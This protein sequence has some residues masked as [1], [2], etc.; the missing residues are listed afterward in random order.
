MQQLQVDKDVFAWLVDFGLV[1]PKGGG[2]GAKVAASGPQVL[3]VRLVAGLLSGELMVE[4]LNSIF[5]KHH[6]KVELLAHVGDRLKTWQQVCRGLRKL[7]C[8]LDD[9]S[10]QALAGGDIDLVVELLSEVMQVYKHWAAMEARKRRKQQQLQNQRRTGGSKGAGYANGYGGHP[11]VVASSGAPSP[12][13]KSAHADDTAARGGGASS[14]TSPARAAPRSD[15]APEEAL[16]VAASS[17]PVTAEQQQQHQQQQLQDSTPREPHADER[18]LA[19]ASP[20]PGP[21]HQPGDDALA[22]DEMARVLDRGPGLPAVHSLE[23]CSL[24]EWATALSSLTPGRSLDGATSAPELLAAAMMQDLK[25]KPEQARSLLLEDARR[26][27]RAFLDSHERNCGHL[28]RWLETLSIYSRPMAEL[29][30]LQPRFVVPVLGAVGH[31]LRAASPAVAE[32]A[33]KVLAGIC[34]GLSSHRLGRSYVVAWVDESPLLTDLVALLVK[35]PKASVT[36]AAFVA[37]YGG[38]SPKAF[39]TLFSQQLKQA[40][41]GEQEYLGTV[42]LLLKAFLEHP[43]DIPEAAEACARQGVVSHFLHRCVQRLGDDWNTPGTQQAA[44][45]MA[46]ELWLCVAARGGRAMVNSTVALAEAA[47]SVLPE[48]LSDLLSALKRASQNSRCPTLQL[49]A[50]GCLTKMLSV[51][52]ERHDPEN[53]PA[54]YRTFVYALIEAENESVRDFAMQNLIHILR[55]H[56]GVPVG[57]LIEPMMK[58]FQAVA[59]DRHLLTVSDVELF[60]VIVEHPRCT[61]AHGEVLAKVLAVASVESKTFGRAATVPLLGVLRRFA[62]HR[63]IVSFFE[64]FVQTCLSRLIQRN[65]SKE[66]VIQVQEVLAKVVSL[67]IPVLESVVRAL[68]GEIARAY[69][70]SFEQLHPN[71]QALVELWPADVNEVKALEAGGQAAGGGAQDEAI[72]SERQDELR[73]RSI[74]PS[75]YGELPETP[76]RQ[77]AGS[78]RLAMAIS[79]EASRLSPKL[80]SHRRMQRDAGDRDRLQ[81]LA[82]E[83][84][85]MRQELTRAKEQQKRATEEAEH[86]RT[87]LS[88]ARKLHSEVETEVAELQRRCQ[89]LQSKKKGESKKMASDKRKKQA[90]EEGATPDKEDLEKASKLVQAFQEPVGILFSSYAKKAKTGKGSALAVDIFEQM[91]VDLELIPA[92]LPK[93]SAQKVVQ[94]AKLKPEGDMLSLPEFSTLL[95]LVASRAFSAEAAV[96]I[97]DFG[98]TVPATSNSGAE[99]STQAMILH[100][101]NFAAAASTPLARSL[102]PSMSRARRHYVVEYAQGKAMELN[103]RLGKGEE[104]QD[105]DMPEG[106]EVQIRKPPPT[107]GVMPG[108]PVATSYRHCAEI[109]DDICAAAVGIH[110][111]EPIA[112]SKPTPQVVVAGHPDFAALLAEVAPRG[113]GSRPTGQQQAKRGQ[114]P[115]RPAPDSPQQ[116]RAHDSHAHDGPTPASAAAAGSQS[117]N[118]ADNSGRTANQRQPRATSVERSPG[119][120][121][122]EGSVPRQERSRQ[123]SASPE[124]RPAARRAANAPASATARTGEAPAAGRKVAGPAG[125]QAKDSGA[126]DRQPK[127]PGSKPAA[128][129]KRKAAAKPAASRGESKA[130][131]KQA[132]ELGKLRQ[133]A[134][135]ALLQSKEVSD[136]LKALQGGLRRL[137]DFFQKW[138]GGKDGTMALQGFIML[139]EYV[140]L[141]N[142]DA[143]KVIFGRVAGQGLSAEALPEA[144]LLCVVRLTEAATGDASLQLSEEVEA[145]RKDFLALLSHLQ[146]TK[147][148]ELQLCLDNYRRVGDTLPRFES[149]FSQASAGAQPAKMA[150]GVLD[151]TMPKADGIMPDLAE[152]ADEPVVEVRPPAEEQVAEKREAAAE[153]QAAATEAAA[154]P[155]T[156]V[157]DAATQEQAADGPKPDEPTAA[158][159]AGAESTKDDAAP[160]AAEPGPQ[161]ASTD[162]ATPDAAPPPEQ[163]DAAGAPAATQEV[164]EAKEGGAEP[165]GTSAASPEATAAIPQEVPAEGDDAGAAP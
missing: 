17:S 13:T 7:E 147:A 84:E 41:R 125:A 111:L 157:P 159:E 49:L 57:V 59:E 83:T 25:I 137:Y 62:E 154:A 155:I 151:T 50:F 122:R 86:L 150:D 123:P 70:S 14:P 3:P 165:A 37:T 23:R 79:M 55:K 63:S 92:L 109:L 120:A 87:D 163:Q 80:D 135:Q 64:S 101:Q 19:E 45:L 46:C 107:Y 1:R 66:Q 105:S 76:A 74:T 68:L 146:L 121:R 126:E 58:K 153:E 136:K 12:S 143:L 85:A 42:H 24:A 39:M 21:G 54:V 129:A 114:Q 162:D 82:E 160:A 71:L 118:Q 26:L 89:D 60:T 116:Q 38:T 56:S 117:Q 127:D 128:V 72:G 11:G 36:A 52:C 119:S 75:A 8:E 132:S 94:T 97:E 144:L 152:A 93:K 90:V 95:P 100:M 4:L 161:G 115:V 51:L 65:C 27:G 139:G 91:L 149:S 32:A 77:D 43:H 133:E 15:V 16:P 112:Q 29:L 10:V 18:R 141:L 96:P 108:L 164:A 88:D 104:L 48:T 33:V 148:K 47:N 99:N 30:L 102:K 67:Q 113:E 140:G 81:Q 138:K 131:H 103:S 34:G 156:E 124:I 142:K 28:L 134:M 73:L 5:K 22:A 35:E 2:A 40:A 98:I 106:F 130:L 158:T 69:L 44:A 53:T 9:E 31:G 20:V 110:F 61:V 145:W 78:P 6:V